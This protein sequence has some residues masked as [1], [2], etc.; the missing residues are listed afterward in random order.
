MPSPTVNHSGVPR[1]MASA[2]P[3]HMS[4]HRHRH[5]NKHPEAGENEGEGS[6]TA[7]RSYNDGVQSFIASDKVE[8]AA[9]EAKQF[10]EHD[11][12]Q[13][14]RDE[15]AGKAGPRPLVHRVEE[16]IT[17]GRAMVDRTVSRVKSLIAKRRAHS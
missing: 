11:P 14:E 15:M 16:L 4:N 9:L 13:A 6:R 17:G 3:G 8:P 5:P 7:A 12:T 2:P 1:G 10:V